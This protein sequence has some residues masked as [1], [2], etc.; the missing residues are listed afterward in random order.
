M[1]LAGALAAG[2]EDVIFGAGNSSEAVGKSLRGPEDSL[3]SKD[4][5]ILATTS[6]V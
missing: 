1:L 6:V 2:A 5:N 3:L 4:L